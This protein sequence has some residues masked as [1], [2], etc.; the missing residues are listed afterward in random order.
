M[1]DLARAYGELIM[2]K[3][4]SQAAQKIEGP[5]QDTIECLQLLFRL[6]AL[7][8]LNDNIGLWLEVEYLNGDHA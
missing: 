1:H 5:N 6:F 7:T 3:E 4:F 8:K 2:V